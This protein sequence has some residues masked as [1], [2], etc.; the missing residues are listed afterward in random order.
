MKRFISIPILVF[1]ISVFA[2]PATAVLSMVED[3]ETNFLPEGWTS[4]HLGNSSSWMWGWSPA[5]GGLH[6]AEMRPAWNNAL[7]DD[8]LVTPAFD[9]SGQQHLL[10]DFWESGRFWSTGGGV[11]EVLVST[12][13]ATDPEAFTSVWQATPSDYE[14]PWLDSWRDEW[15]NVPIDLS[16]Y[17]GETIYVAFRYFS[18]LSEDYWW[19][20]DVR[21]RAPSDHE[22]RALAIQPNGESWLTGQEIAPQME[23]ENIGPNVESFPV[24]MVIEHNGMV[25]FNETVQVSD[26]LPGTK[27]VVEF[28]PFICQSGEYLL[29]GTAILPNDGDPSDNTATA[30]NNC[31]S[32]LRNPLGILFT[33]WAC[34]PCVPANIA[35]N[36]WYPAQGNGAGLIRV[37]LY[38]PSSQDPMYLANPEESQHLRSM[39]PEE[40]N[41]VPLLYLDNT[42]SVEVNQDIGW[43]TLIS[44]NYAQRMAVGTPLELSASFDSQD[45]TVS[46]NI[47]VLDPMPEGSF[48]LHVAVTEDDVYAPGSNGEE[49]HNQAFRRLFPDLMGTSIATSQGNHQYTLDLELSPEWAYENL[50]ATVWVQE[51]SGGAILNSATTQFNAVSAVDPAMSSQIELQK[52]N[53]HPNPFNPRTIISFEV[54]NPGR[55]SLVVYDMAGRLIATLMD[56][57]VA[58]GQHEVFW[59]GRDSMGR[60]APSGMYFSRLKAGGQVQ[61]GRMMLL[62]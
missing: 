5:H 27:T 14:A 6:S 28:A 47:H 11:H 62:R 34:D 51:D 33:N 44:D 48:S 52:L 15:V 23:V 42:L 7:K 38:W 45:S 50:H 37:H 3:F 53:S 1:L 31:Y 25:V 39:C 56:G 2:T 40:V 18:E 29:Q 60:S 57:Q 59:N 54:A 13:V 36:E 35:L 21:L 61:Q 20:D 46:V 41:S 26:L 19:I 49:H 30:D 24:E 12:T 32:V 43:P 16:A 17:S 55:V 8:W 10:L 9:S 4:L 22:V 58:A